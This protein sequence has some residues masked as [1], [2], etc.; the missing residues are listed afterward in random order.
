MAQ[1]AAALA[2]AHARGLIHRDVKPA[3]VLLDAGGE[4]DHAYLT[5][6][7][8]ARHAAATSGLTR[9]GS[10]IGTLD[11][12]APERIQDQGGDGRSDVY[13]LGCVLF[14]AVTGTLPYARENDVAKMY[15]HLSAPVPSARSVAPDVPEELDELAARA[16][17]KDPA[18]RFATAGEMAEAL[19][20]TLPARPARVREG[21]AGAPAAAAATAPETAPAQSPL[22]VSEEAALAAET[23]AE[24]SPAERRAERAEAETAAAAPPPATPADAPS[25][26]VPAD[27]P[28]TIAPV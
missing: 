16:M 7:G 18:D 17:A 3:N 9:T 4:R 13:A 6:F 27:A 26:A 22:G 28:P 10:V 2:A 8:I 19:A 24:L 12:L 14:E 25:A 11:Y 1:V 5:D 23:A 20:D 15:A 21:P